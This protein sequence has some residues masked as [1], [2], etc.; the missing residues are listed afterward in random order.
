MEQIMVRYIFQLFF[1]NSKLNL[2]L[3]LRFPF[4]LEGTGIC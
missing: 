3:F 4:T 2:T 1:K